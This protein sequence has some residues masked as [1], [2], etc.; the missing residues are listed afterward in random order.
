MEYGDASDIGKREWS[1]ELL[2]AIDTETEI[3]KYPPPFVK[4]SELIGGTNHQSSIEYGM[5]KGVAVAAGVGDIMMAAI[6]TGTVIPGR[7]T[8][9]LDSSGTVFAFSEKPIIDRTGISPP[10]AAPSMAS[11]HYCAQ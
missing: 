5:P 7:L 3:Q 9:S 4:S 1:T 6:G 8:V 10:F 2:S 11:Y